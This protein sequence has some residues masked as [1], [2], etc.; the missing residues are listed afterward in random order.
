MATE[1]ILVKVS[2][3]PN[4][5]SDYDS[6]LRWIWAND[7]KR[8]IVY[9]TDQSGHYWDGTYSVKEHSR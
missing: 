2:D 6:F 9:S 4:A 8:P 5:P 3:K 1:K 7:S